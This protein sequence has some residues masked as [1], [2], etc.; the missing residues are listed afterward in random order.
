MFR[1]FADV[2]NFAFEVMRSAYGPSKRPAKFKLDSFASLLGFD[3]PQHAANFV[4]LFGLPVE[5]EGD[6]EEARLIINSPLFCHPDD[7][8]PQK[9]LQWIKQMQAGTT[10]GD[11]VNGE[12]LPPYELHIPKDSFGDAVDVAESQEDAQQRTQQLAQLSTQ[13]KQLSMQAS[14]LRSALG[15]VNKKL[16]LQ[17]NTVRQ[18]KQQQ[19]ASQEADETRSQAL[20]EEKAVVMEAAS[21]AVAEELLDNQVSEAAAEEARDALLFGKSIMFAADVMIA[22]VVSQNTKVVAKETLEDIKQERLRLAE[23]VSK[24][25]LNEFLSSQIKTLANVVCEEHASEQRFFRGM[26]E[27]IFDGLVQDLVADYVPQVALDSSLWLKFRQ[28]ETQRLAR[29]FKHWKLAMK[30]RSLLRSFPPAPMFLRTGSK[31]RR[32]D[33]LNPDAAPFVAASGMTVKTPVEVQ[34]SHADSTRRLAKR[35]RHADVYR[36]VWQPLSLAETLLPPLM[37]ANP[38]VKELF[39]K[40][41]LCVSESTEWNLEYWLQ[42]KFNLADADSSVQEAKHEGSS[43]VLRTCANLVKRPSAGLLQSTNVI[44]FVV[45]NCTESF[46]WKAER[47]RLRS[48]VDSLAMTMPACLVVLHP[49][50]PKDNGRV[51]GSLELSALPNRPLQV[52]TSSIVSSGTDRG[53]FANGV[54]SDAFVWA[55]SMLPSQEQLGLK[56][57]RLSELTEMVLTRHFTHHASWSPEHII[58][59]LNACLVRVEKIAAARSKGFPP[60]PPAELSTSKPSKPASVKV[61]RLPELPALPVECQQLLAHPADLS[62]QDR[63]FLWDSDVARCLAY[64]NSVI[65]SHSFEEAPMLMSVRSLLHDASLSDGRVPWAAIIEAIASHVACGPTMSQQVTFE[66]PR[67]DQPV[68]YRPPRKSTHPFSKLVAQSPRL[69]RKIEQSEDSKG[70]AKSAR[71]STP[72]VSISTALA[73]HQLN[74]LDKLNDVVSREQAEAREFEE[75]LQ[76]AVAAGPQ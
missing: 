37:A 18:A 24:E 67:L 10:L 29:K 33:G 63:V 51:E 6:L 28:F 61:P 42:Q 4:Q 13:Q 73:G 43:V 41:A 15:E 2:R 1:H 52:A 70:P 60:W 44:V 17:R 76:A 3:S 30:H 58:A 56:S 72:I 54:L 31:K 49:Y 26:Q 45:A 14:K 22:E 65:D 46:Q 47:R 35:A 5:T 59:Q 11:L 19:Q 48:V 16:T 21:K 32:H 20:A 66:A 23:S 9:K 34:A 27:S 57:T 53:S 25:M 38:E 39:F 7:P 62:L 74:A 71:L 12:V 55:A 8:P 50:P 68:T 36:K 69:K 40:V 75:M 64:V